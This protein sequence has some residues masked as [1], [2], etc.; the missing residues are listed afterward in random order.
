M[1]GEPVITIIGGRVGKDPE[2]RVLKNGTAV[3]T[4]PVAVTTRK[5]EGDKWVDDT[6]TWF[7]VS[8]F[9]K[10][11]EA[12]METV[13]KGDKVIVIGRFVMSEYVNKEQQKVQSPEITADGI[14]VMGRSAAKPQQQTPIDNNPW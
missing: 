5:K 11:G 9:G 6:T 1:A 12:T 4:L 14:A 7:R 3:A 8:Q 10:D 13:R 2:L